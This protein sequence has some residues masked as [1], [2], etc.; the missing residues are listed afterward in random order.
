[1]RQ[2]ALKRLSLLMGLLCCWNGNAVPQ[3]MQPYVVDY[4]EHLLGDQFCKR[5]YQLARDLQSV[6]ELYKIEFYF[7]SGTLLGAVRHQGLI[8]W[9]DDLDLCMLKQH[10][11][12]FARKVIPKLDELGWEVSRHKARWKG[13]MIKDKIIR[14]GFRRAK[15][16]IFLI[17]EKNGI[18][19]YDGTWPWMVLR[20]DQ[21]RP[22]G[23]LLFG[24]IQI[25]V[26][27]DYQDFLTQNFG[28]T[29]KDKAIKYN[30]G[31]LRQPPGFKPSLTYNCGSHMQRRL[32]NLKLQKS[33]DLNVE[34]STGPFLP[35]G[36]FS[37]SD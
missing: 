2:Q 15:C 19:K 10:N 7:S 20:S 23:K 11:D 6:M 34:T 16:D 5:L 17:V 30:H 14:E 13:Y 22:I 21:V 25:N 29:W 18:C 8:P 3:S 36:P 4:E 28:P 37:E 26:P 1:M 35:A 32:A 12:I 31:E 27:N 9:D 33:G 24:D